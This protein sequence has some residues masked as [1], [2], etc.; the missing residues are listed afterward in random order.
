MCLTLGASLLLVNLGTGIPLVHSR[1]RESPLRCSTVIG[2][3][4]DSSKSIHC[5]PLCPLEPEAYSGK[6][7]VTCLCSLKARS[8]SNSSLHSHRTSIMF[9]SRKVFSI[10][11]LNELMKEWETSNERST[12]ESSKARGL[13]FPHSVA[14]ER[15]AHKAIH[16]L[17]TQY[18]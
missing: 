15:I 6:T 1:G 4:R 11:L 12:N 16:V 3:E 17:Y 2:S 13:G 10:Y 9:S 8:I 5:L 18:L 7:I 14:N